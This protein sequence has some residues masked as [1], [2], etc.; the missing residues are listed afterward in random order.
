METVVILVWVP[1]SEYGAGYVA[2]PSLAADKGSVNR[3]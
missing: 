1:V 3:G 2:R